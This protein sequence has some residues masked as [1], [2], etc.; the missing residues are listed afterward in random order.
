M[1]VVWTAAAQA[2]LKSIYDY[3]AAHSV[4]HPQCTPMP[5]APNE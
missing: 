3:I 2:Q 1:K 5:N 4:V